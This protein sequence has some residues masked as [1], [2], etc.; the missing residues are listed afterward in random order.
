MG[1]T[2]FLLSCS[3]TP[4]TE[5]V[6]QGSVKMEIAKC[7]DTIPA[8]W[9]VVISVSSVDQYPGWVQVWFQDGGGNLYMI[10]YHIESNTFH[11]NYRHLKRQ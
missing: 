9:G 1:F 7:G 5:P 4:E 2:V 3:K 6:I 8:A 11:M 10:P